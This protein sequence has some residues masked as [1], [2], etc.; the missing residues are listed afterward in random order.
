MFPKISA[1]IV[2]NTKTTKDHK[3]HLQWFFPKNTGYFI[4]K[5]NKKVLVLDKTTYQELGKEPLSFASKVI[6]FSKNSNLKTDTYKIVNSVGGALKVIEK[7]GKGALLIC[8]AKTL[9]LFLDNNS[10]DCV[11]VAK[12]DCSVGN[13]ASTNQIEQNF[14]RLQPTVEELDF[15][16]YGQEHLIVFETYLRKR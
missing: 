2:I 15:D 8:S 12:I 1:F 5:I 14:S 16:K 3:N 7:I 4:S 13:G 11:H 6:I 10:V 9:D